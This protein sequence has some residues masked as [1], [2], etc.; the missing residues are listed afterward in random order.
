M[1][2]VQIGGALLALLSGS[3]NAQVPTPYICGQTAYVHTCT[4]GC[5][6]EVWDDK[7][8][9]GQHAIFKGS[10]ANL[11]GVYF[12]PESLGDA[13]M[14]VA[15]MAR[16]YGL[17]SYEVNDR[18]SSYKVKYG[19]WLFCIDAGGSDKND[20]CNPSERVPGI[21]QYWS[22]VPLGKNNSNLLEF[23]Q[24]IQDTISSLTCIPDP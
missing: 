19:K 22:N 8:F 17:G 10:I 13:S 9:S 4:A 14:T 16:N 2:I 23:N 1:K 20:G 3:A 7:D 21:D 18:I 5:E 24:H 6:I 12:A 11:A 15:N